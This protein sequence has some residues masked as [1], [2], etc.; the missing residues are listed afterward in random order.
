M[1]FLRNVTSESLLNWEDTALLNLLTSCSLIEQSGAWED[2]WS[3]SD[4]LREHNFGELIGCNAVSAVG[5]APNQDRDDLVI[6]T[7]LSSRKRRQ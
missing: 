1:Q 4:L 5:P 3:P 7:F 2:R 6:D